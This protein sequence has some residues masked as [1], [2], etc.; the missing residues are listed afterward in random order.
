MA[1]YPETSITLVG[2]S[3]GGFY[4]TWLAEKYGVRAVLINPATDPHMGLHAYLGRQHGYHGGESYELTEEHLRQWEELLVAVVHPERYLL[5][6]ETRRSAGLP[7]GGKEIPGRK[8]GRGAR[9]GPHARELSR[10]ASAHSRIRRD[11]LITSVPSRR[12]CL[13]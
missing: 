6:V 12:I 4:A 13:P 7:R 2:S 10:A 8:T 1:R 5:L 9:R 11:E 3:L